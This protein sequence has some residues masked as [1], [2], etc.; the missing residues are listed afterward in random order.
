[1]AAAPLSP[2]EPDPG[3]REE[4]VKDNHALRGPLKR[5]AGGKAIFA[6]QFSLWSNG[7]RETGVLRLSEITA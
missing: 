2:N 1:M 4:L 5:S 3:M 6:L 7:E